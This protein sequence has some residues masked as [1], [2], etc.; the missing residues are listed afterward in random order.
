MSLPGK[1]IIRNAPRA[2]PN[3]LEYYWYP[4]TDTGGNPI[5]GYQ[6]SLDPGGITCNI[7]ASQLAPTYGYYKVTGLA[8]ATT[9][10]TTIAASTISGYGPTANFRAFQAGSA[11]L[12]SASTTTAAY[13]GVTNALIS[14]TPPITSPDATI[15]WYVIKSKSSNPADPVLKYTANGLTQNTY[16]VKGLNPYSTYYFTINAV[17]CPGYSPPAS[18][19]TVTYGLPYLPSY[20]SGNFMWMDA[21]D[22][23]TLTLSGA[24]VTQWRDKSQ[25]TYATNTV[26]GTTSVLAGGLNDLNVLGFSSSYLFAPIAPAWNGERMT[27]LI[28]GTLCNVNT[29]P[30][31]LAAGRCNV[32]DTLDSSVAALFYRNTT[33]TNITT[34]RNNITFQT[35]LSAYQTPFLG[36]AVL[37]TGQIQQALNGANPGTSNGT[38]SSLFNVNMIAFGGDTNTAN[39]ANT[40]S[41]RIGEIVMFNIDL[42]PFARQKMEGYLA[43]KW[44]IQSLLPTSHPFYINK[45]LSNQSFSPTLFSSLQLWLDA[46]D[47]TTVTL[48]SGRVISWADKSGNGYNA[49]TRINGSNIVYGTQLN[50]LNTLSFDRTA[51][52]GTFTT[53]YTGSNLY[54]FAVAYYSN[55]AS[56]YER[57][58][59]MGLA[60]ATDFNN[61]SYT[62]AFSR[63]NNTTQLV[64]DRNASA[65]VSVTNTSPFLVMSYGIPGTIGIGVNGG[66]PTTTAA[67]SLG[68]SLTNYRVA[69]TLGSINASDCMPGTI[70]ELLV[71]TRA[72]STGERQTV[73]GYLAWKW[74]L[75]SNLPDT[76]PYKYMNPSS[77]YTT[78][79]YVPQN[80]L[81][82]FTA[83]TYSGSGQWSNNSPVYGSSH[84]AALE[85]GTIAKNAGG[86]G[87]VFNGSTSYRFPPATSA[88]GGQAQTRWTMSVWFKRTGS[89][90]DNSC[91]VTN[92]YTG[93]NINMYFRL[94][95]GG[96]VQFS[97]GFFSGGG[98]YDGNAYA[99][100]LNTWVHMCVT[101]NGSAIVTYINGSI[102]GS[103]SVTATPGAS[104]SY[105]LLGRKWDASAYVIGETGEV[106]IYNR[107][108]YSSEI[109]QNYQNTYLTYVTTAPILKYTASTWDGTGSWPN[110][111]SLG[112]AYNA[113]LNSGS[114]TKNGAGNGVVLNGSTSYIITT[115]DFGSAFTVLFW[116]KRTAVNNA[117]S[118]ILGQPI[119]G[120][121][122]GRTMVQ[123]ISGAAGATNTQFL[124]RSNEKFDSS[125]SIVPFPTNAWEFMAVS[126]NKLGTVNM[127]TYVDGSTY[128][129]T[130]PSGAG[131]WW[132][133]ALYIGSLSA[134]ANTGV[135]G[136]LGELAVYTRILTPSEIQQYYQTTRSTYGV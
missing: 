127:V 126:Y 106:M 51:I 125:S 114:R 87:V 133:A 119:G 77:N 52:Q 39:T 10:F 20:V 19:N 27:A 40:L 6:L 92:I 122:D 91:I 98:F 50:G 54:S 112:V 81:V 76:H 128:G 36:S 110:T 85:N 78:S 37:T 121:G 108:L 34:F 101:Y 13:S 116:F 86:N 43:W 16:F 132:N 99:F 3:T 55:T 105:Y 1:P 31:F 123:I 104:G 38:N 96:G 33:G 69:G 12:F 124:L 7:P 129:T 30:R 111:G 21:S 60:G 15:F 88:F 35:A 79:N 46:S 32:N 72:L 102:Y 113:G 24:T 44:G 5:E 41:G 14:W 26:G 56:G 29:S 53:T 80:Q 109:L 134:G 131:S 115:Y 59:S 58:L 8:N 47:T 82:R 42:D 11:P 135:V 103:V 89:C 70:A 68:Y 4:P 49:T 17:N 90:P 45:P 75:Q 136:E 9:Y 22:S 62:N 117:G 94:S 57:I 66:S 74:G 63:N 61:T 71:Y 93:G 28:V 18:T 64:T 23:T 67:T 2:S 97:G 84:N 83:N 130:A 118:V 73:E 65:T 95:V 48:S 107:A 100:P 25:F 120:G